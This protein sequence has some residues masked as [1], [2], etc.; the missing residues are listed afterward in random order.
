MHYILPLGVNYAAKSIAGVPYSHKDFAPLQVMAKLLSLKFLHVEIREKG[1]AYGSGL[2]VTSSGLLNFFSYRDPNAM[3]TLDT[4]DRCSE[5]IKSNA[6]EKREIEESIM[7]IFK[8][9]DA[10]IPPGSRGMDRF[11]YDRDDAAIEKH[12]LALFNVSEEDV[13][14]VAETYLSRTGSRALIGPENND[15]NKITNENWTQQ[16]MDM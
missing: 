16:K 12:R 7:G 4:F 9:I 8:T 5:W 2:S 15:L 1:G 3:K 6:F 11:F 14:R 10:P 13:K